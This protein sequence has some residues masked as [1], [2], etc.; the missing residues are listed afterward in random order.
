MNVEMYSD[1]LEAR[2]APSG[3]VV[4]SVRVSVRARRDS[5]EGVSRGA[6]RVRLAAPPVEGKANDALRRLLAD[7][8]NVARSAVRI[9][10]G[11]HSRL[12]RVEIGGVRLERVLQL[13]S[14]ASQ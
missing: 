1:T 13:A 2:V 6:L 9:T 8:L 12:K 4:F 14:A 7:R 5:I 3:A 10:S 11:E